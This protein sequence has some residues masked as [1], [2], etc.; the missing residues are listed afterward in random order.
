[1][2]LAPISADPQALVALRRDVMDICAATAFIVV[3]VATC[4]V[5]M[6]RRRS[7]VRIFLWLGLW[8]AVYGVNFLW[9]P[10]RPIAPPWFQTIAPGMKALNMYLVLP[11]ASASWMEATRG[12][13]RKF[14]VWLVF[15]ELCV[16]A[17]GF[18]TYFVTG[19]AYRWLTPNNI[20]ATIGSGTLL[21]V[22]ASKKLF[23]KF[24]VMPSRGFFALG[25]FVF[26]LEAL[27]TNLL[28]SFGYVAPSIVGHL[29]FALLLAAFGH[30]ALQMVVDRERRLL[31][32]ESELQLARQIQRAI[33]PKE[34]P[35]IRD[36]KIE[37]E[38]HPAASVAGDFYE[39]ISVDRE[40]AGFLV[41]DVCGHGVPA[42]LIASMLKVAVQAVRECADRPGKFL[43]A[44]NRNLAE[45]LHGQLIS[46]AYLWID[47]AQQKAVYSAAGHPP[48]LHRNKHVE[49]IESN[50]LLFGVL[51]ETEYPE[52]Q[53]AI[54]PGDRLLLYTDGVSEPE[55]AKGEAFG[56]ARLLAMME[57]SAAE[58]VSEVRSWQ[59][60][61]ED[62]MT[63]VGIEIA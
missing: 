39:F 60:M 19:D 61:Q 18:V 53:I 44:L 45:S 34:L 12:W 30:S 27:T 32:I 63:L 43:T 5:A 51:P 17:C 9:M 29:G 49:M 59:P 3:G 2:L 57:K 20:L 31:S 40:H 28:G 21:A 11:C 50:G 37:A 46:A 15:F 38:Y 33:L 4:A 36:L 56:E 26:T 54:H 14:S 23:E 47:M 13:M 22:V 25:A 55:N 52:R 42:A 7:G 62:D 35:E 58:I 41:A 24:T 10:L 16:A 8:S 48:L 1:M 6:A